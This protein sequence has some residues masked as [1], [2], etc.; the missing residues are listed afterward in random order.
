MIDPTAT[1]TLPTSGPNTSASSSLAQLNNDYQA[2]LKLL[3][4]QVANQ[5][6]LAPMDS[7]TFVSQLAQLS[8]VEQSVQVN[9]NLQEISARIAGAVAISD[10]SLIGRNVSVA[11]DQVVPSTAGTRIG[12]ELA[13]PANAVAAR[14]IGPDGTV[15]RSFEGLSTLSETMHELAWDS[16]DMEGLPVVGEGPFRV[17]IEAVD[18]DGKSVPHQTYVS[19]EVESV[20]FRNGMPMLILDSGLEVASS[21]VRLVE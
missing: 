5:D 11:G 1:A 2:F 6:P 9:T 3:T 15:L 12:Y 16:L 4:A 18:E 8:Q 10:V 14:I 7:S 21:S 19:G 17:Q 13:E 20:V